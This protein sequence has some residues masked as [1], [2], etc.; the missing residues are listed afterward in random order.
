MNIAVPTENFVKEITNNLINTMTTEIR[1]QVVHDVATAVMD[2]DLSAEIRAQI[3]GAVSKAIEHYM[4]VDSQGRINPYVNNPVTGAVFNQFVNRT[5]QFLQSLMQHVNNDIVSDLFTKLNS[6]NIHDMIIEETRLT[7]ER[8]L[9]R[10]TWQFPP[11]S[12]PVETL[13]TEHIRIPASNLL[14]GMITGFHSVGIQDRASEAQLTITDSITVVE[15]RLVAHS[16]DIH[17]DLA[18]KGTVNTEFIQDIVKRT[19]SDIQTA[20]KDGVYDQYCDRVITKLTDQ[21]LD[22]SLVKIHGESLV[23]DQTMNPRVTKSNLKRVG[24]LEELQ[25][26]G[27]TVLDHT[28]YVSNKRMGVNTLEPERVF[29]LWD[30]EVQVIMSKRQRDVAM[31]GTLRN[32]RVILSSNNRDNVILDPDGSCTVSELRIGKITHSSSDTRPRDQKPQGHIV[33]NSQPS[34]GH[35]IGWISL[36]GARWAQFGTIQD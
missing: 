5:E 21:G 25:V 9:Q 23:I 6:I 1:Q 10:S 4:D 26:S 20:H 7:V 28:V 22:V 17:G 13:Q 14:P 33:W 16:L 32:Q 35:A 12:I 19:I 8:L 30:Q 11:R 24:L 2:F 27:E 34:L 18:I 31:I 29:D 36:G 15:N 3:N